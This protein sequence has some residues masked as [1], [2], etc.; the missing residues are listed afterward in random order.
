MDNQ[1]LIKQLLYDLRKFSNMKN[2]LYLQKCEALRVLYIREDDFSHALGIN[3]EMR[4]KI[5][6]MLENSKLMANERKRLLKKYWQTFLFAAPFDFHS[7]LLY[8]EKDRDTEKRFYQPRIKVLRNIVRDLQDLADGK[9]MRLALSMPPGSG[10]S[11]L[12][13]FYI[14]WLMGKEPLKPSLATAYAD[15]LTRSFFDGALQ[16]IRDP[17]YK[18]NEIFPDSPLVATN[19]KDETIDLRQIKRFKTLTC[20]SIDSGL[21]GAT[22]CEV[23]SV[24]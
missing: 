22:R 7:F 18:F 20:R 11:T 16:I 15:K 6:L 12:G 13:I 9:L 8:M 2:D 3:L 10:K 21:T 19:S 23:F 17:E 24:C 4:K 5:N 14:V 1:E